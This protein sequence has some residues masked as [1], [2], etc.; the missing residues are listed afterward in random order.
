MIHVLTIHWQSEEWI[1]IQLK[2]LHYH[3]K[4]PFRVYSFLNNVPNYQEHKKKFF[5]TSN[6]NIKSH[7]V[8]LNLLADIA[9][10]A[11]ESDNDYLLFLDG[12]AFPINSIDEFK[13]RVFPKHPLAAIQRFENNGDIQPHPCFC[14]TTVAYWK[15]INGDW[16]P[17]NITWQDTYNNK[18]GDVGGILLDK[19][20]KLNVDWYR[21]LRSNNNNIHPLLF[22]I[23]DSLIYHHGAAFRRPGTRIDKNKIKN[24][25]KK[26]SRFLLL[27]KILPATIVKKYFLPLKNELKENQRNSDQIYQAIQNDFQFFKALGDKVE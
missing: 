1:D 18:I 21:L 3:I 26:R 25:D 15:K 16:K 17:G 24:F 12:D 20:N 11:A 6:E 9:S 2:Y 23:Y 22:G 4:E 14:M 19:M 7:P 27:K 8:K 5:Y 10:F 13:N